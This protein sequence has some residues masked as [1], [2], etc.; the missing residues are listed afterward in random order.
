M[1]QHRYKTE[2]WKVKTSN[3]V[4]KLKNLKQEMQKKCHF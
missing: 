4:G 1:Q 3:Q 2:T